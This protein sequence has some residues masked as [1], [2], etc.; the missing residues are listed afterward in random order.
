MLVDRNSYLPNCTF[1]DAIKA[2]LT[3]TKQISRHFGSSRVPLELLLLIL[4][5]LPL[6]E[7][8]VCRQACRFLRD[9]IDQTPSLQYTIELVL[10]GMED[11][12][13]SPLS[14]S[15]KLKL[16]RNRHVALTTFEPNPLVLAREVD[17]SGNFQGLFHGL[18]LIEKGTG[19]F[20]N[21]I[22]EILSL[23]QPSLG[24]EESRWSLDFSKLESYSPH[25]EID[26]SQELVVM[27]FV[28]PDDS[29]IRFL[30]TSNMNQHPSCQQDHIRLVQLPQSGDIDQGDVKII[31]EGNKVGICVECHLPQAAGR[32]SSYMFMVMNWRTGAII[33]KTSNF[34]LCSFGFLDSS[35]VVFFQATEDAEFNRTLDLSVISFNAAGVGCN[36]QEEVKYLVH[37][38]ALPP[39]GYP[40]IALCCNN[41]APW[42]RNHNAPFRQAS[43]MRLFTLEVEILADNYG[44][45]EVYPLRLCIPSSTFYCHLHVHESSEHSDS[46]SAPIS[47]IPWAVWG[48]AGTRL[49]REPFVIN[50]SQSFGTRY[51][52]ISNDHHV[53][54]LDF[55]PY[56]V[57]YYASRSHL[58]DQMETRHGINALLVQGPTAIGQYVGT[59]GDVVELDVEKR[60]REKICPTPPE[61]MNDSESEDEDELEIIIPEDY[62]TEYFS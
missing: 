4:E 24:I 61:W 36:P 62:P 29:Y 6:H 47:M 12:P 45:M 22:F 57:R 46:P 23:A 38:F 16:L 34:G 48:P 31:I 28:S 11:I 41:P 55:N 1:A 39:W 14:R 9:I 37:K 51:A 13:S 5:Q 58:L 3:R 25:W 18:L 33:F 30:S 44:R 43:S 42:I 32:E 2:P 54:L 8:L 50:H 17:S 19:D 49:F 26:M 52:T 15:K 59:P 20:P 53:T 10:N 56:A 60:A 21:N 40:E 35:N 27:A 7:L